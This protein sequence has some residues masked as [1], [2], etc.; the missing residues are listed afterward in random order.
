MRLSRALPIVLLDLFSGIGGFAKGLLQAGYS[1]RKLYFSETDRYAIANYFYHFK[2]AEYVGPVEKISAKKIERPDIIT[3]GFPCQDLSIANSRRGLHGS[4]SG[5]FFEAIKLIQK[6]KPGVFIFENVK[7]LFSSNKGKD[8]EIVLKEI[9]D[10]GLYDCEWQ[11]L[12]TRWFLPQNRERIYFIGHL[13]GSS[14]PK[15]FPFTQ[16][17]F[18]SGPEETSQVAY[19]I[20]ATRGL[21]NTDNY[22][23]T[24]KDYRNARTLTPLECE[25]LQGYPD[26][27]TQHGVIGNQ[28]IEL[29]DRIRYLLIGNAVSV[30]VVEA[31]ARRLKVIHRSKPQMDKLNQLELEH[32]AIVLEREL[33]LLRI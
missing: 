21:R 10:I 3:F 4:R 15:V 16:N 27:W 23:I 33:K 14:T 1:F 20:A 11:L 17:D 32:E 18:P 8:F 12:N 9:A 22:V 24:S 5:L 31:I 2:F 26:H 6:L 29:S 7:G 19:T 30:P 13:R 28:H 25:R